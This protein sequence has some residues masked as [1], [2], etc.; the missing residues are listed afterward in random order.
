M[1]IGRPLKAGTAKLA[2]RLPGE[3][4]DLPRTLVNQV[5]F[6]VVINKSNHM[7]TSQK[8]IVDNFAG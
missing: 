5:E 3:L 7:V 8:Q 6:I 1:E 4:S 2:S